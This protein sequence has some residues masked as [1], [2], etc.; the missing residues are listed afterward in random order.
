MKSASRTDV[1]RD[2]CQILSE[3]FDILR[4]KSE[5]RENLNH[6]GIF[7]PLAPAIE[8]LHD[9][10]IAGGDDDVLGDIALHLER[11]GQY[12]HGLGIEDEV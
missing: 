11:L 2:P 4:L 6:P 10:V 8:P 1:H 3:R 12:V 7:R 5:S 9:N